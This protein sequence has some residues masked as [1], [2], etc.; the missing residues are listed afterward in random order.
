MSI[1]FLTQ[2]DTTPITSYGRCPIFWQTYPLIGLLI[3]YLLALL[4]FA[5]FI[6][7]GVRDVHHMRKEYLTTLGLGLT[8]TTLQIIS[9]TTSWL[10]FTDPYL[11]PNF[12]L[13]VGLITIHIISVCYPLF[14]IRVKLR[15]ESRLV[16]TEQLQFDQILQTPF[17]FEEFKRF[18]ADQFTVNYALFYERCRDLQI[19][20]RRLEDSTSEAKVAEFIPISKDSTL[21]LNETAIVVDLDPEISE[22]VEPWMIN[23]L[24]GIYKAFIDQ[25]AYMRIELNKNLQDEIRRKYENSEI[26]LS[27]YDDALREV[28]HLLRKGS[29]PQYLGCRLRTRS[30][31]S[32]TRLKRKNK[33][34][35]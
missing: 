29:Y 14:Y 7:R 6:H 12:W 4:I 10:E 23:E 1:H 28:Y 26:S 19:L 25:D 31:P 22:K 8:F 20:S 5:F 34:D 18:T 35:K 17:L 13:L 27:W 15:R 21:E 11:T 30:C 33:F 2:V 32:S 9:S 24:K 16:A 3:L